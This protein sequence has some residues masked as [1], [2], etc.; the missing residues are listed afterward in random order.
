MT[1]FESRSLDAQSWDLFIVELDAPDDPAF[2]A[3]RTMTP[4]WDLGGS[5]P[6]AGQ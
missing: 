3:L 5:P 1:V 6:G 2:A 4:V